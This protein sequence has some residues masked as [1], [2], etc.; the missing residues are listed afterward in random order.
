M[1]VRNQRR[2]S[3]GELFCDEV[4]NGMG[5]GLGRL[6]KVRDAV[7]LI[8]QANHGGRKNDSAGGC[9]GEA[10]GVHGRR[11]GTAGEKLS[12]GFGGR[13]ERPGYFEVH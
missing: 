7:P 12:G 1:A 13:A 4:R 5:E 6:F 8:V 9:G 10:R 3:A 11:I 2:A